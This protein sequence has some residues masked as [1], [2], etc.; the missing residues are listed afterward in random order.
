[1]M[2]DAPRPVTLNGIDRDGK[3][4]WVYCN[5]CGRERDVPPATL[6]LPM[7]TPVPAAGKRLICSACRSRKVTVKPEL[8]PGAIEAMREKHRGR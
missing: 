1:M 5:A 4:A 6:G 2:T 3:L 8:Y 7:N